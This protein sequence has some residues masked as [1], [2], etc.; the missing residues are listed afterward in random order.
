MEKFMGEV[1]AGLAEEIF[2]NGFDFGVIMG[3]TDGFAL[4]LG[5]EAGGS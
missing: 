2:V 3:F 4:V 1:S 5:I